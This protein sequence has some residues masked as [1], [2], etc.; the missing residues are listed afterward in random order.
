[1]SIKELRSIAP[2]PSC[3]VN[4]I[5]LLSEAD[6]KGLP[7]LPPDDIEFISTYG[8]CSFYRHVFILSPYRKDNY[9]LFEW[10]KSNASQL[11]SLFSGP[12]AKLNNDLLPLLPITI[13]P[14][15]Q[16]TAFMRG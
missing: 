2:P 6:E 14:E 1:M 7:E 12:L 11:K 4:D 13:Y 9:S 16:W 15:S 8:E 10:H 3:P 5:A